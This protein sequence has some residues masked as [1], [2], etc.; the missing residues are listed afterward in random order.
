MHMRTCIHTHTQIFHES[1]S[2]SV[3]VGYGISYTHTKYTNTSCDPKVFRQVVLKEYYAL[4]LAADTVN[5]YYC[6]SC[7][8]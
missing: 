3:T 4:H 5:M 8:T 2:L 1:V 7:N 6:A